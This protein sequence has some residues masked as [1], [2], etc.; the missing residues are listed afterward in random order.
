M[1]NDTIQKM[2]PER[3]WAAP[4]PAEN[5]IDTAVS[6]ETTATPAI[7]RPA[8]PPRRR[9]QRAWFGWLGFPSRSEA[10]QHIRIIGRHFLS[11]TGFRP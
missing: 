8:R 11:L 1:D 2:K 7:H 10:A 9:R 5:P 3:P 6:G 4:P